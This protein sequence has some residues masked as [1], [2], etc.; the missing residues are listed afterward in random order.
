MTETFDLSLEQAHAYED[1]FVPAL[2]AQWVP[3]LLRHAG[4]GPGLRVVDVACGTGVVARAASEVVGPGGQVSGVDL[5]PAMVQVARECVPG[6]DWRVG[7]AGDLPYGDASFD[8]SLCQ[9]ALF[10]FPD[11]AAACREM[12]RVVRPGGTVALQTYAE[13]ADQPGYGPFVDAVVRHAGDGARRLLGTYWS[14]GDVAQFRA[15]LDEAGA[16]P[17]SSESVL[18]EVSFPSVEALV[19]TEVG[20]TPLADRIDPAAYVAL[21]RDVRDVLAD[22]V[23]EQGAVTMPVRAV[24]VAGRKR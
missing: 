5:N 8:A 23:D 6:L 18:G 2:F 7:D 10:F 9:S 3:T 22:F 21:A 14:R 13:L 11:P 12:V 4:V 1:L 19:Q 24:F 15:L 20:A 16:E 17:T